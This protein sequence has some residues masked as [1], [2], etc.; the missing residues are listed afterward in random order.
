VNGKSELQEEISQ[1]SPGDNITVTI[2]RGGKDMDIP[3]A[4]NGQNVTSDNKITILGATFEPLGEKEKTQLRLRNGFKITRIEP[5]KLKDAGIK[6]GFILVNIDKQP[7]S[8]TKDIEDA[9]SSSEGGV[10]ID[11][12]YPNGMRAYYGITL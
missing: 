9:L 1:L 12:L 6:E 3:V 10:L 5:G 11:G 7:V 2:S 8:T 4:M